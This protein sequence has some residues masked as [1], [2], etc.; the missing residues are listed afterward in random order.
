MCALSQVMGEVVVSDCINWKGTVSNSGYGLTYNPETQKTI[1]AHRLVYY[2]HH[3]CYPK[4]V[5]HTCDNPLCVNPKHL[6]AGTQNEYMKKLDEKSWQYWT[7]SENVKAENQKITDLNSSIAL[8]RT[9]QD[10]LSEQ[11]KTLKETTA[12]EEIKRDDFFTWTGGI[13]GQKPENVEFFMAVLPAIFIDI[14]AP[15]ALGVLFGL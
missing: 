12:K 15:I 3:G 8:L 9:E 10:A 5:M 1:S 2:Q 6:K 14:V 4:V 7:A 11:K 13:T